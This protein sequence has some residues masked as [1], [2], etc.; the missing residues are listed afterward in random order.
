MSRELS[1]FWREHGIKTKK[2]EKN[3]GQALASNGASKRQQ[4]Q[5]DEVTDAFLQSIIR[6][7]I[8]KEKN[9]GVQAGTYL[10]GFAAELRKHGKTIEGN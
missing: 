7:A 3:R 2:L 6:V 9:T 8:N 4:F 5:V 1:K 10:E